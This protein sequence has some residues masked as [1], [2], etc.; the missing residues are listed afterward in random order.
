[1]LNKSKSNSI[2]W[3]GWKTEV[4][5]KAKDEN[6]PIF[7]SIEESYSQWSLLM[8]KESFSQESISELLNSRFIAI[9]VTA[10]EHPELAKFYQKV[11]KLMNRS[12]AG[13]PLSIFMTE[14]LEP[15]YAGSY[16]APEAQKELLGFEALLRVVSNKYITDYN[17]LVEKG[18]EVLENIHSKE[19]KIEATRLHL[20]IL[21]TIITHSKNLIDKEYGGFGTAIKFINSS[22]LELMLDTYELTKEKSLLDNVINAL[23]AMYKGNLYDHIESGFYSYTT[24]RAWKKPYL[25]KNSYD[26]ALLIKMYLRAYQL[27]ANNVYKNIAFKSIDFMLNNMSKSKLFFAKNY[28]NN[29]TN[30]TI[31]TSWNSMMISTLFTASMIDDKYQQIAVESL[32]RLLDELYIHK[33]LYHVMQPNSQPQI[34]AFLEDYAY[35]GD[36]LV[37]AYQTTLDESYLVMATQFANILIEQFYKYGK[38][39]FSNGSFKIE[40]EIFD[41][42][43]PSSVAVAGSLLMSIS[44]L[45]DNNYKKF[46]FKTLEVNSYNLMRQPLSSPKLTQ[47]LLRYLKDDII[48]KSNESLLKQSINKRNLMGYPY[49]IYKTTVDKEILLCNSSSILAKTTNFTEIE[50]LIKSY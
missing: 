18:K 46:V 33:K 6:K 30:Q 22:T 13:F 8:E 11:H 7:L 43:Y 45:V 35:L 40:E 17:T 48:I 2:Y 49:I 4:F 28:N 38:W 39:N 23:D 44:S 34:E 42:P 21:K 10:H 25:V 14:N 31:I 16:I 24:D 1:M 15:F 50:R 47:L 26:N 19:Q 41:T 27:T 12:K 5:Q 37:T 20:D 3:Y 29:R 36:T 32:Q 9:K